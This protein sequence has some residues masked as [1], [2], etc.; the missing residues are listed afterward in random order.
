[1]RL[2][3]SPSGHGD[4]L[5]HSHRVGKRRPS[6]RRKQRS[7][8]CGASTCFRGSGHGAGNETRTR[9]PDLGKVVLYQ[10][11]YSRMEDAVA[12]S[13]YWRPGSELNRRT[14]ICS[15]LHNHSATRP[16]ATAPDWRNPGAF[17]R[18]LQNK[19]PHAG[20]CRC[21]LRSESGAGNETGTRALNPCFPITFSAAVSSEG[22]NY[23]LVFRP[24]QQSSSNN[25]HQRPRTAIPSPDKGSRTHGDHRPAPATLLARPG[26][27]AS[28]MTSASSVETALGSMSRAPRP[29]A[30]RDEGYAGSEQRWVACSHR[31][32]GCDRLGATRNSLKLATAHDRW[33]L[34]RY[35]RMPEQA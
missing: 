23:S 12:S 13:W 32:V 30:V 16:M 3:V 10:L 31:L 28:G 20:L 21:F 5:P 26:L 19:T 34:C 4:S 1:M 25:F 22:L 27:L 8:A 6:G 35:I 9:D 2:P 29:K 15:P 24:R 17:S 11:S 33:M 7:P 14:R 18:R